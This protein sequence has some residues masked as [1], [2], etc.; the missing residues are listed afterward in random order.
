MMDPVI[1]ERY[2]DYGVYMNPSAVDELIRNNCTMPN[3]ERVI[4]NLSKADVM[5]TVE[6]EENGKKIKKQEKT[7]EQRYVLATIVT[8]IDG[9]KVT[10]KNSLTDAVDVIEKSVGD[11]K[12]TV[13]SDAAKERGLV[14]AIFK[15]LKS[16]PD[17]NGLCVDG[18]VGRIL[19]E[20]VDGAYDQQFE[21]TKNKVAKA[22]AKLEYERKLG[23]S[24]PKA[25]R[26]SLNDTLSRINV[27]LD[28]FG[29]DKTI[30]DTVAS[31]FK[32]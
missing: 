19:R 27:L 1:Y 25:P 18:G 32:N 10:V 4:F 7:G 21:A 26:Y 5:K 2:S 9:T 13:A 29:G 6:T 16:V 12:V 22:A 8:F 28:K 20:M 17:K 30:L 31:I 14:F 3:I 24:K 15:R 23:T 11:T